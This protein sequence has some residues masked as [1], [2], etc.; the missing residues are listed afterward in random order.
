VVLALG[1]GDLTDGAGSAPGWFP[2]DGLGEGELGSGGGVCGDM[3]GVSG[4][5]TGDG[6]CEEVR[7]GRTKVLEVVVDEVCRVAVFSDVD[8]VDPAGSTEIVAAVVEVSS[9]P[10]G[11]DMSIEVVKVVGARTD[12]SVD[13]VF[14]AMLVKLVAMLLPASMVL[15]R[16]TFVHRLPRN[17][18]IEDIGRAS[19]DA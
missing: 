2:E 9:G 15:F 1:L 12:E 16:R 11:C 13:S 18:V 5:A 8:G 4:L 6:A 17:V 10:E 14:V 3:A 19:R 7:A